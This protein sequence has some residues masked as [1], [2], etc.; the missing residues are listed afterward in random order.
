MISITAALLVIIGILLFALIIFFHEFGHFIT[1]KK[2]G[3][4]VNEF[5]IGMGPKLFSFIRGE[6]KY[7]LRLLPIGGYCAMEGEDEQSDDPHAFHNVKIWKQM[8]IV[9]AGAVMN[10]FFG[11]VLMFIILVQQPYLS[12]TTVQSFPQL[13][14]SANSGLQAGDKILKVDSTSVLSSRD[15]SY[16]VQT[17]VLRTVDGSDLQI[18]REDCCI[19]LYR[20]FTDNLSDKYQYIS[21]IPAEITDVLNDYI[22]KINSAQSIREAENVFTEGYAALNEACSNFEYTIPEISVQDER[23]RFRSDIT[24]LRNGE[25][26]VLNDVDFYTYKNSDGEI[27]VSVD[28]YVEPLEKNFISLISQ[29][30]KETVSTVKTV[31]AGL[32]GIVQGKFGFNDISGPIGAT[33]AIVQA[34]SAGLESDFWSGLNNLIFMMMVISVN[35]GIVNM[36]PFPALDGG[37]FLLLLIEAIRKKPLPRKFEGYINAAGLIILLAFMLVISLKDVW[38]LIGG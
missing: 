8:I 35:L 2:S 22:S 16:A 11:F 12:S 18:F 28:F 38:M 7:S 34:T 30:F 4:K 14:F 24:V 26:T 1:A 21:D 20:S 9:A 19:E 15:I 5:S 37:R 27:C 32:V 17:A 3:V 33:S 36:L 25:K 13:S 29:T 31:W 6:T 23:Q 10:I